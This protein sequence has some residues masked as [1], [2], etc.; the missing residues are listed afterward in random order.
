MWRQSTR[1]CSRSRRYRSSI[2]RESAQGMVEYILIVS[3]VVG[4]I[5]TLGR[6]FFKTV[7]EQISQSYKEGIF[8]NPQTSFYY[9]PVKSRR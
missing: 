5:L 4:I 9:F 1:G 6:P 8:G 2:R 7:R 3:I